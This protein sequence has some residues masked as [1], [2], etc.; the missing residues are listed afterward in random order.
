MFP[1]RRCTNQDNSPA[2][3]VVS[4]PESHSLSPSAQEPVQFELRNLRAHV[5]Y[6]MTFIFEGCLKTFNKR[7]EYTVSSTIFHSGHAIYY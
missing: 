3:P 7:R 2:D 4:F 1:V 5:V 6:H